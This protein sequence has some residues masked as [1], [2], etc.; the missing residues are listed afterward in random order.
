MVEHPDVVFALNQP[1]LDRF[2]PKIAKGGIL[3]YDSD[4]AKPQEINRPHH[5]GIP[6]FSLAIACDAPKSANLVLLGAWLKT[7][8]SN[9]EAILHALH[10]LLTSN[11][12]K[13]IQAGMDC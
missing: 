1:A 12:I 8:S 6:A 10:N 13:A 5:V 3:F 2:S 9:R 11:Q 7:L 4:S